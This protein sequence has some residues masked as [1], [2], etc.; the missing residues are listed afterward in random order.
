MDKKQELQELERQKR[1][2]EKR[3][4]ALKETAID[5]GNVRISKRF[6]KYTVSISLDMGQGK[7]RHMAVVRHITKDELL[8]WT[9]ETIANL[10]NAIEEV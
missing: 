4:K 8:K 2:L 10:D 3:I 5:K 6:D 9:H 1:E 7:V